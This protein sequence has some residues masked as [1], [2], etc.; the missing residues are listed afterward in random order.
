M[1]AKEAVATS[2]LRA[3][4]RIL[5]ALRG[6]DPFLA[7]GRPRP[8]RDV[9]R[10]RRDVHDRPGDRS[11]CRTG[12]AVR[13]L[14]VRAGPP[15]AWRSGGPSGRARP[16]LPGVRDR[17]HLTRLV[18]GGD[19]GRL[20]LVRVDDPLSR[21]AGGPWTA[22]SWH[23][24]E[25]GSRGRSGDGRPPRPPVPGMWGPA[26]VHDRCRGCAHGGVRPVWQ[27]LHAPTADVRPGDRASPRPDTGLSVRLPAARS[28]TL[29]GSPRRGPFPASRGRTTEVPPARPGGRI[30]RGR[31]SRAPPASPA[32]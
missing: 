27:P 19:R 1:P 15:G 2:P 24:G 13:P 5:S 30:G 9:P 10:M 18:R 17:A 3:H 16:R 11:R 28:G 32:S 26:L 31:S 12:F 29:R 4:G 14:R 21:D 25:K 22:T 23:V 8:A 20:R 6:L 7:P